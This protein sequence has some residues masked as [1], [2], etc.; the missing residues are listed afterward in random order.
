MIKMKKDEEIFIPLGMEELWKSL[1]FDVTDILE[2]NG[3]DTQV[4]G[5]S[6]E[7]KQLSNEQKETIANEIV[8]Q[9]FKRLVIDIF[10]FEVE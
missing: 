10:G 4:D 2:K 3:L 7:V 1:I 5:F 8:E 9:I 6:K